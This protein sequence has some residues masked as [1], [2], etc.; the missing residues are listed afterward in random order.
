MSYQI[1][2]ARYARDKMAIRCESD[3]SGLKTRAMRI[4]AGLPGARYSNR[5]HAY[6]VSKRQADRFEALMA[7]GYDATFIHGEVYMPQHS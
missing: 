5:E 2:K 4:A 7:D 6:I 1:T 3:G